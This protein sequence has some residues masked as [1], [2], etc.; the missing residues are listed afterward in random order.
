MMPV[1][2][3]GCVWRAGALLLVSLAPLSLE[4]QSTETL[5]APVQS[6]SLPKW[7]IDAG[8]KMEF[9]SSSIRK[10]VSG[11]LKTP[12]FP[13][14]ADDGLP[15]HDGT[16][17]ADFPL[18]VYIQF[19]YKLWLTPEET[20]ILYANLPKWVVSD[21]YEIHAQAAVKPTKDQM[22]LMMQSLLAERFGLKVHFENRQLPVFVLTMI[23]PGKLGPRLRPHTNICDAFVAAK[24]GPGVFP[25]PCLDQALMTIPRPNRVK[26]TGTRNT[27]VAMIATYLPSIGELD[28]PVVD[29]TGLPGRYD[30]SLEFTPE[31]SL[32]EPSGPDAES[33]SQATTLYDALARQLGLQLRPAKAPRDVLVVDH[34]EWPT[35]N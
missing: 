5:A 33:D 20:R 15:P 17:S 26:L 30:F 21:P 1:F 18:M 16:F 27:T 34:V 13:L 2:T 4:A 19:A 22:R 12:N 14:S 10:D 9:A 35:E 28:R 3:M 11:K 24:N 31:S 32:P 23:K 8:G 29:A 7:Q 6:A 25:P